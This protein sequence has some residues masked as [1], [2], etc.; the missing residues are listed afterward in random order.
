MFTFLICP[1]GKNTTCFL[2]SFHSKCCQDGV[3]TDM[4][5]LFKK[6]YYSINMWD[7]CVSVADSHLKCTWPASPTGHLLEDNGKLLESVSKSVPQSLTEKVSSGVKSARSN[8]EGSVRS[9][10]MIQG[11]SSLVSWQ[12]GAMKVGRLAPPFL[13]DQI[14]KRCAVF[15]ELPSSPPFNGPWFIL[16]YHQIP[17][18]LFCIPTVDSAILSY[19]V[20]SSGTLKGAGEGASLLLG[21]TLFKIFR[22]LCAGGCQIRL[23][24]NTIVKKRASHT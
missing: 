16:W 1:T 10:W 13:Q 8:G 3:R 12:N 19:N 20:I 24:W 4:V 9:G 22:I 15:L 21:V 18:S 17:G 14:C 5:M 6:I 7:C 2:K 11:K 23:I